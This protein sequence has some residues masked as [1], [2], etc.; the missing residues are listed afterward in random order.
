MGC[1]YWLLF[2]WWLELFR[3]FIE[4]LLLPFRLVSASLRAFLWLV[5]VLFLIVLFVM[6]GVPILLICF[7]VF[8]VGALIY[9]F[10]VGKGKGPG[11]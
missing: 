7:L 8:F 2:G 9:C 11:V 10:F 5:V 3:L 4:L 1:L 6:V